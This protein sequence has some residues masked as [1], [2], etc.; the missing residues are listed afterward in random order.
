M[1]RCADAG[2]RLVLAPNRNDAVIRAA[3]A[4]GLVAMPGVATPLPAGVRM[5]L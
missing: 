4:R 1:A 5:V 2:A 3:V